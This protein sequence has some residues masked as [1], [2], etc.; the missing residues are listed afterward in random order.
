MQLQSK[1]NKKHTF[2]ILLDS[3][4]ILL[5]T[6][7]IFLKMNKKQAFTFLLL[8]LYASERKK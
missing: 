1:T 8:K 4:C 3:Y 2:R 6:R 7:Y 5:N